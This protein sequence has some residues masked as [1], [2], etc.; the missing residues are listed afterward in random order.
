M[1][2]EIVLPDLHYAL[3]DLPN[4]I[5]A[6]LHEI[7]A[8]HDAAMAEAFL[9]HT[10]AAVVASALAVLGREATCRMLTHQPQAAQ[11]WEA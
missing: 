9:E 6:I 5:P 2:S 8:S 7:V 1:H 3:S 10:L 11:E 4:G